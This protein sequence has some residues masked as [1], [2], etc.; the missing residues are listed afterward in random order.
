MSLCAAVG[1]NISSYIRKSYLEGNLSFLYYL[2]VFVPYNGTTLGDAECALLGAKLRQWMEHNPWWREACQ[3]P[4]AFMT[5]RQNPKVCKLLRIKEFANEMDRPRFDNA[6]GLELGASFVG[7]VP[8]SD[9]FEY[10][11][12]GHH[13]QI[14][15]RALSDQ[16][17]IY[18]NSCGTY[19]LVVSV[20]DKALPFWSSSKAF[21][22]AMLASGFDAEVLVMH[23]YFG[24]FF[25]NPVLSTNLG[26]LEL[27]R[28]QLEDLAL[29]VNC[30]KWSSPRIGHDVEL[31]LI[32]H[33]MVQEDARF[34]EY[35]LS[36]KGIDL[37]PLLRKCPIMA[38]SA[39]PEYG[40]LLHYLHAIIG[41]LLNGKFDMNRLKQLLSQDGVDVDRGPQV[42][43]LG[44]EVIT[45]LYAALCSAIRFD[46]DF[47]LVK[48]YVEAGANVGPA[49]SVASSREFDQGFGRGIAANSRFLYLRVRRAIANDGSYEISVDVMKSKHQRLLASVRQL[50]GESGQE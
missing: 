33:S 19:N 10:S 39:V 17:Y 21:R 13:A 8:R 34:F 50:I 38:E 45:P 22:D 4:S 9:D 26:L 25:L 36:F 49:L 18:W 3:S 7:F 27:L 37:N 28:F 2:S 14:H 48:A 35:L 31:P 5:Q 32:L 46:S 29:D 15:V 47:D 41:G 40:T 42:P 16:V 12:E 11:I 20:N 43:A 23:Q 1:P 6:H 24:L 44:P 30:Q